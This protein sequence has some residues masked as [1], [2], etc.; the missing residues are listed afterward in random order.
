MGNPLGQPS[1]WQTT[2]EAG[3]ASQGVIAMCYGMGC[4][5]E[6]SYGECRYPYRTFLAEDGCACMKREE[7]WEGEGGEEETNEGEEE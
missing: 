3:V 7:D 6:D 1:L 4:R 2:N 5:W